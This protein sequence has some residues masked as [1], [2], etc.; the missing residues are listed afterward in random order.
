MSQASLIPTAS[1]SPIFNFKSHEIRTVMQDGEPWFVAKDVCAAMAI[2]WVGGKTLPVIQGDWQGVGFFPTPRGGVQKFIIISEPAVYKL[3][4]RSNKEEADIFTNWLASEVLPAI[5][6]TGK[7]EAA[8]KPVRP[9]KALGSGIPELPPARKRPFVERLHLT[10]WE[11]FSIG[12]ENMAALERADKVGPR[13]L[14]CILL[15]LRYIEAL[16]DMSKL[17]NDL[18]ADLDRVRRGVFGK[19]VQAGNQTGCMT[20]PVMD[21]LCD[22]TWL[23]RRLGNDLHTTAF[24]GLNASICGAKMLGV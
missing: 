6:K 5:R 18:A 24:R 11:K 7:Y 8:E 9:R 19:L 16:H 2:K 12:K 22:D 3:A 4:F 10:Q 17:I 15:K 20:D 23:L 21:I 13:T 1:P 14:E